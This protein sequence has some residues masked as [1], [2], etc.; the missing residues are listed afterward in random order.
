LRTADIQ[1]DTIDQT[2][3]EGTFV[4]PKVWT[5]Q[6]SLPSALN[7]MLSH[8]NK[9]FSKCESVRFCLPDKDQTSDELQYIVPGC[10]AY[11]ELY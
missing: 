5:Y 11:T 4:N 2:S 1:T 7:L 9:A 10:V 8:F 6:V 3:K